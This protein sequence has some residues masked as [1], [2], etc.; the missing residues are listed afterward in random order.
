[1]SYLLRFGLPPLTPEEEGE[2]VKIVKEDE[3]GLY[4]KK[5]LL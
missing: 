5:N 1:M 2:L 3:E 4:G